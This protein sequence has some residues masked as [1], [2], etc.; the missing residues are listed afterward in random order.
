MW[1]IFLRDF[2]SAPPRLIIDDPPGRSEWALDR[3]PRVASLLANYH[4]CQIADDLCVYLRK[5]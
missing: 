5:D 4:P 3:Y 2:S 1:P